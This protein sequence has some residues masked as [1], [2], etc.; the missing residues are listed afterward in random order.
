[1]T[2]A[3]DAVTVEPAALRR[4][5]LLASSLAGR[6]IV[7]V[8]SPERATWTDGRS[9]HVATA[10]APG[11]WAAE[12]VVQ[13]GLLGQGSLD[14]AAIDELTR[15]GR[16]VAHRYLLL[17]GDRALRAL[18][19]VLPGV[20]VGGWDPAAVP[21]PSSGAGESLLRAKSREVLPTPPI[22]FGVLHPRRLLPPEDRST[23]AR[24]Q[25]VPAPSRPA[26]DPL[27]ELDE[28]DEG[29]AVSR[30]A[31]L[32]ASPTGKPSALGTMLASLL[33][34]RR[35]WTGSGGNHRGGSPSVVSRGAGVG[36][37]LVVDQHAPPPVIHEEAGGPTT[38][39]YPEWDEGRGCY[40]LGWCTVVEREA[41][42]DALRSTPRLPLVPPPWLRAQLAPLA[43]GLQRRHRQP[44]GVDID[45]DAMV[46]AQIALAA[47]RTP[48]DRVHV[49]LR[50]TGRN[51]GVLVL[52]DASGSGADASS[53]GGTI[54]DHQ[55]AAAAALMT[56]C[57]E[58]G[59]RVALYAFR[60]HGRAAVHLDTVKGFD[61]PH[62][63]RVQ[64]RL[65]SV[66]AHAFTRF[67]AAVR[68]ATTLVRTRSGTER[69]L[70]VVLSDGFAYDDGYEGPYA[71]ADAR[72]SLEEARAG[73]VGCVALNVGGGADD[74]SL[75]RVFTASAHA[76]VA[77]L[78]DLDG[79]LG[80]L[81]AAALALAEVR[82][83]QFEHRRAHVMDERLVRM[84]A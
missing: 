76:R 21:S 1:M 5:D 54:L 52:L 75:Q 56:T 84:G 45:L 68:H 70:L 63:E 42:I 79:N 31:R 26:E 73:G 81:F 3:D 61:E 53:S 66:H 51:L 47:G 69:K 22:T 83:R 41:P 36:G 15:G 39:A 38:G 2:T 50:R 71:E 64:A 44:S 18:A 11:R 59:D 40:R 20:R 17:E 6:S 32:L 82:H 28:D 13:A 37:S 19:A 60:S 46:D 77:R 80:Q 49:D 4:F 23:P 55:R 27:D 8:P 24:V 25:A 30:W 62:D 57:A 16:G 9:I 7:V 72:R 33:G 14:Q 10:A 35:S 43:R 67:G 65:A 34:L 78:D 74:R 58:L 48:T 29:E 12:T